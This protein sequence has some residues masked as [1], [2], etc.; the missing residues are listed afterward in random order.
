LVTTP[1]LARQVHADLAEFGEIAPMPQRRFGRL[2]STAMRTAGRLTLA[3]AGFRRAVHG[4][5]RRVIHG[6]TVAWL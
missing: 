5:G 2:P 1:D 4:G 6:L 3:G